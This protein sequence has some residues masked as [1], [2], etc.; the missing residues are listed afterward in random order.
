MKIFLD[1]GYGC[2]LNYLNYYFKREL[3]SKHYNITADPSDADILIFPKNCCCTFYDMIKTFSHIEVVLAQKK[4]TAQTLLIGCLTR[5]SN[6]PVNSCIA[7]WISR[8]IDFVFPQNSPELLLKHISQQSFASLEKD[9]GFYIH[10]DKS[11]AVY[12]SNGCQNNCSFCKLTFQKYPLSSANFEKVLYF[13]DQIDDKKLPSLFLKGTN[14]CQFGLDNY[15]THKLPELLEYIDAKENIK[16][17]SLVGFSFKDAIKNNFQDVLANSK[18][19][20][21]LCGS[22]ESGSDRILELMRKGFT[23]QEIIDFVNSIRKSNDIGLYLN[24]IAG[25]PTEN[26]DDIKQTLYVLNEMRA[27]EVNICRYTNSLFVDSNQFRQ[28]SAEQIHDSARCYKKVLTQRGV[29]AHISG[30]G[31][32]LENS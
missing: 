8:N 19:N 23:S 1:E 20:Y 7:D 25:F 2:S 12:I 11:A 5:E 22:L 4:D 15:S 30:F 24:I 14:I 3:L 10:D 27:P 21:T 29:K 16:N 28:L 13:I 17:V 32:S 31:Y 26:I 18:K 9:F 6:S